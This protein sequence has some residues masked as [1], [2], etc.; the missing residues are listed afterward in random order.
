MENQNYQEDHQI[1]I[2]SAAIKDMSCNYTYEL[3][4]GKTKG[5][6]MKKRTGAQII[7]EDL[8]KAFKELDV[9]LAHI[10]GAFTSFANN[11]TPIQDLEADEVLSN[12]VVNG[13]KISGSDE[14]KS[15]II[16]G[17]KE[18]GYGIIHF[19]T[20]KIKLNSTY[21][22]VEE[23]E[24]R[25]NVALNEVEEYMNGKTAPQF[26]QLEINFDATQENEDDFQNAKID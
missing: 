14:N 5:D 6:V 13:F 16:S 20:P 21:L 2:R 26:E 22:Y 9:F 4:F 10:D 24:E 18:T 7:H 15:V 23:L 1:E 8:D 19:D 17:F 25:L 3:L 11:Q 12:Y